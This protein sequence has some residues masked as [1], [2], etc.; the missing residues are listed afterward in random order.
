[1]EPQCQPLDLILA[2]RD[3]RNKTLIWEALLSRTLD[4]QIMLLQLKIL[5]VFLKATQCL[6]TRDLLIASDQLV[7]PL[8]TLLPA[9]QITITMLDLPLLILLD[10]PPPPL[11]HLPPP[12]PP[13]SARHQPQTLT[14]FPKETLSLPILERPRA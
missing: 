1:M 4:L 3:P 7:G 10:L 2:H 14:A 11:L 12:L 6:P 8:L 5:M 9:L 13:P